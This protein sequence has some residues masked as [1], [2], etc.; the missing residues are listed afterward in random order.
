MMTNKKLKGT[1]AKR[2]NKFR[3]NRVVIY[4]NDIQLLTGKSYRHALT[5]N[6]EIKDYYKKKK[7]QY[8]TIQE[9]SEYTGISLDIIH[10]YLP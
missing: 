7:K 9:F 4:P 8:L 10:K 1:K 6:K 2:K 3:L 5:L